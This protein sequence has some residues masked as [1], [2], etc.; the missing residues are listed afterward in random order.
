MTK[1]QDGAAVPHRRP[2]FK[3]RYNPIGKQGKQEKISFKNHR[4]P[5]PVMDRD[6]MPRALQVPLEQD[7]LENSPTTP[8]TPATPSPESIPNPSPPNEPSRSLAV[9]IESPG[10]CTEPPARAHEPEMKPGGLHDRTDRN[11]FPC[12]YMS[13]QTHGTQRHLLAKA[14]VRVQ[15]FRTQRRQLNHSLMHLGLI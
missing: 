6:P 14:M 11:M 2:S 3:I 7:L 12:S 15:I 8:A 10:E 5:A 4:G 13:L 1:D 9:S